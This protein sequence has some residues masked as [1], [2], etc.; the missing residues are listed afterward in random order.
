MSDTKKYKG[1][2]L[3]IEGSRSGADVAST[4][5][6]YNA[7]CQVEYI[8][9]AKF[10]SSEDAA[11]W[12]LEKISYDVDENAT[13]IQIATNK[14]Y[15][16]IITIDVDITTNTPDI[17]VTLTGLAAALKHTIFA[18]DQVNITTV[19]NGSKIQGIIKSWDKQTNTMVI[20]VAGVTGIVAESGTVLGATDF[21]ITL[22]NP[23][24][25]DFAK[26]VWSLR[27]QYIYQ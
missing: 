8:A 4:K 17:T 14:I 19:V 15:T 10:G 2:E 13:D 16:G 11:A 22:N 20:D 6:D 1:Q 23:S 27:T 5:L 24:T 7:S 9:E 21:I 3:I 26:R 25:K 18:N 12:Y